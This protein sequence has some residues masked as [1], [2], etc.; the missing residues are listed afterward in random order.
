[1]AKQ[2]LRELYVDE[3]RD[4]YDAENRLVKALPQMAK[5]AESED[6]RA[7]FEEHLEQ[8][9]GHVDRLRQILEALNH[10]PSGKK[11]A[12]MVGLIQE[13]EELM[14]EDFE[15]GVKDAALISAAQRVEH[16]EI[17]AYGCVRTWAGLLGET[18][19]QSLLEQT[20]SEEKATDT[21]LTE[22]SEEINVEATNEGGVQGESDLEPGTVSDGEDSPEEMSRPAPTKATRGKARSARA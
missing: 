10:K 1:M 8:T 9:K 19:A 22:L 3:L 12:A 4:L 21:K 17:A 16:Y 14:D 5:N 13:G 11:C 15:G 18:E 2:S 20:L 7:G 6:L